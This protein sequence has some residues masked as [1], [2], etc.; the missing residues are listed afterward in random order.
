LEKPYTEFESHPDPFYVKGEFAPSDRAALSKRQQ[1]AHNLLQPHMRLL[2]FLGSHFNASR[3]GSPHAEKSFLR[4]LNVTLD[5]LKHS[6]GHPLSREI[7]LQII[8]FGLTVM[9]H[10]TSLNFHSKCLLKDKILSAALSWFSFAPR[11]SFGGNKVQLKAETRLLG[12]V[13]LALRNVQMVT[14]T[15]TPLSQSLLAKESLL[16]ALMESEHV[17]LTV[18]LYPTGEGSSQT[19]KNPTEVCNPTFFGSGFINMYRPLFSVW[20]EQLGTRIHR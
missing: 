3:L 4:L 5:G 20:L 8:L 1:V 7:R 12:D 14:N 2:Q 6:T 9:R 10:V 19:L 17:R 11:W 15:Q 13:S 16:Q 18:W